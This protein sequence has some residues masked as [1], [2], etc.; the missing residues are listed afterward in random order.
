MGPVMGGDGTVDVLVFGNFFLGKKKK[1][2]Y[3]KKKNSFNF[4]SLVAHLNTVK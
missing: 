2:E 4:L 3:T 1:V